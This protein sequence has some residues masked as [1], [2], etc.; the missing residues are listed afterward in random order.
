MFAGA[1]VR[2]ESI[3]LFSVHRLVLVL[4]VDADA[5]EI[6]GAATAPSAAVI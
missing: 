6:V 3:Q 4:A 1:L 5:T 2:G